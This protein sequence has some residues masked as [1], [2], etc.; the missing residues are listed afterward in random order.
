MYKKTRQKNLQCDEF[1]QAYKT[2]VQL[3]YDK[4]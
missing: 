4:T 1:M 3:C 2:N